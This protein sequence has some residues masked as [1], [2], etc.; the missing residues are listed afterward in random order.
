MA[1]AG[2]MA[3]PATAASRLNPSRQAANA[4]GRECFF[5]GMSQGEAGV[6]RMVAPNYEPAAIRLREGR[7]ESHVQG[8]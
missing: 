7:N 6:T 4:R 5:F 1:Q 8:N 2:P 3:L